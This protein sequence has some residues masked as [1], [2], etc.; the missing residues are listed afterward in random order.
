MRIKLI[1]EKCNNMHELNVLNSKAIV[2][3][4]NLEIGGFSYS[5]SDLMINNGKLNELIIRCKCGNYIYVDFQ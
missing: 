2:L 4:D 3:R 5:L 1:C